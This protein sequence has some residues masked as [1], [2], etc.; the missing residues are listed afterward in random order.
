MSTFS[1]RLV[2]SLILVNVPVAGW[3]ELTHDELAEHL[4]A[5]LLA[6]FACEIAVRVALAVRHRRFDR[7][8]LIDAVI[9]TLA[10]L[11]FGVLPVVRVARLT[12]LGRHLVHLSSLRVLRLAV[13]R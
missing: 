9:V 11:P 2:T 6:F 3:A 5:A 1:H 10:V 4:D 7:W 8:L 13:A 12:H